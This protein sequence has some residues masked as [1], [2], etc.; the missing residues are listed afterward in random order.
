MKQYFNC[1]AAILFTCFAASSANAQTSSDVYGGSSDITWLGMDFTQ[2]KFIGTATQFKDAGEISNSDFRDK[3]IPAWNQ[4][5]VNEPK[6]YNVAE[7]TRRTEV[8]YAVDITDKVNSKIKK[9]FFSTSTDEYRTLNESKIADLVKNY[10][11]GGKT[12]IGLIFF[13]DGMSKGKD[14]VSG[15]PTF[16]NMKT[17]KVLLTSNQTGKPGGF[18]FRNFWAKGFLEILKDVKADFKKNK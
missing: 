9:D 18:G 4:L 15:W 13:I 2:V 8:K 1:L 6:K 12:G 14:E 17:K 11:F 7:A 16:V 3:Y 10:D 5:F